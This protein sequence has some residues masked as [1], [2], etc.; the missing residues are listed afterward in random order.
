MYVQDQQIK[1]LTHCDI[2]SI[3]MSF[4][5][6]FWLCLSAWQVAQMERAHSRLQ[7]ELER[8]KDG[9]RT[10]E[11][12]RENKLQVDQLQEQADKLTAEL[13]SLQTAHNALRLLS[14]Q[15]SQCEIYWLM[16]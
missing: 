14:A 8:Y 9:N 3:Y 16:Q 13:S 1:T 11:D 15:S 10:E 4:S 2:Y 12:L 7:S 5:P 6:S